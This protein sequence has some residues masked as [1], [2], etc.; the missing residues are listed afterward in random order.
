MPNIR[1]FNPEILPSNSGKSADHKKF[2]T[3]AVF[4]AIGMLV[5]GG[6][7]WWMGQKKVIEV[8]VSDS[9]NQNG[10]VTLSREESQRKSEAVSSISSEQ[11]KLTPEER[12]KKEAI[13]KAMQEK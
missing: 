6:L 5:I 8:L 7:Y 9:I 10:R 13:L 3:A 1:N 2:I 12:K 11:I 4:A